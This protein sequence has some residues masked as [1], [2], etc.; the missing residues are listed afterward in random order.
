MFFAEPKNHF[1]GKRGRRRRVVGFSTFHPKQQ[2]LHVFS[3]FVLISSSLITLVICS[4][5]RSHNIITTSDNSSERRIRSILN[6]NENINDF[7]K[8]RVLHTNDLHS[9]FDEVTIS[10]SK[11]KDKDR[12]SRTCY[13]GVAR[14]K[15]MVDDIRKQHSKDNNDNVLFLNAGDFFQVCESFI[16]QMCCH[17]YILLLICVIWYF[18]TYID[19]NK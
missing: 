2:Q 6:N 7:V 9:R 18:S 11:C 10:G 12:K 19:L 1:S 16:V 13:G 4:A 5:S 3:L 8:I 14:I 17:L 15:H